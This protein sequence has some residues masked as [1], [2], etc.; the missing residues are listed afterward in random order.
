MENED[1]SALARFSLWVTAMQV[2]WVN[3]NLLV[4]FL[5]HRWR[6]R[7]CRCPWLRERPYVFAHVVDLRR[8]FT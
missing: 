8:A 2:W 3:A 1:A 6:G 5:P 7:L 4:W